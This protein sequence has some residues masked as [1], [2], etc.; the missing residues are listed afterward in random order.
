MATRDSN[1]GRS[2]RSPLGAP[3]PR[4]PVRGGPSMGASRVDLSIPWELLTCPEGMVRA[5]SLSLYLFLSLFVCVRGHST[6]TLRE[7]RVH[8]PR[9]GSMLLRHHCRK[10]FICC[11]KRLNS[12]CIV[13]ASGV[14]TRS[15]YCSKRISCAR[16][17]KGMEGSRDA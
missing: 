15:A 12:K 3:G 11:D 14:T 6:G 17:G 1:I 4:V 9:S 2:R 16:A 13:T 5:L 7:T 10:P 8:E